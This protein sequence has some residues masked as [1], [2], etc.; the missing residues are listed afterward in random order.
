[1]KAS[2]EKTSCPL[3]GGQENRKCF[4]ERGHDV[5]VCRTCELFFIDPYYNDAQEK[6]QTRVYGTLNTQG[7]ARH[8]AASQWTLQR[9]F[10]AI[11][12]WFTGAQSV[13]DIGC[14]PGNL[15]KLLGE[16]M[17]HLRRVGVELDA[18]RA[19]FARASAHCEVYEMPVEHFTSPGRFEVITMIDVLSHISSIGALF[20]ALRRLLAAD[21]KLILKVGEMTPEVKKDAI[22]DWGIPDHLHF[23]GMH[24]IDHLCHKYG[25]TVVSHDRRLLSEE[26][27]SFGRWWGPGRNSARN[28]VKKVV[29]VTPF[30]LSTLRRVYNRRHGTSVFSSLIVMSPLPEG[31]TPP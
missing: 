26:L 24:T 1:M 18:E 8:H 31:S 27:F 6:M 4:S 2:G 28:V 30:A 14:G 20:A 16:R 21:G 19:A 5:L 3:C 9:Y 15:L 13:L 7:P 22:Y 23:L 10:P 11:E 12:R 17:P 29:A 25:F